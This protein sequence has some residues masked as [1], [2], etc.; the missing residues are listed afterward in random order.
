[1][2][3]IIVGGGKVGTYLAT[4]LSGRGEAVKVIESSREEFPL[5]MRILPP[6]SLVTGSGSD[7]AVLESAGIRRVDVVAAVTGSD[8]TNL[9]VAGLARFEFG[10]RRVIARI[11]HPANAWMFTPKMG[12]DVALN[13]ADLLVHLILEE[14]SVG[15]MMTLLKLRKGEYS[16]VAEKVHGNSPAVGKSIAM[17]NLPDECVIT[18]VIRKGRLT[19]PRGNLVLHAEDEVLS[20]VHSSRIAFLAALLGEKEDQK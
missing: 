19:I 4:L 15:E 12:V 16:L 3:V 5:L 7:P 1:M 2:E 18:A 13:Q 9:V 6:G 8:E 11:N 17:L 20:V 10:V 14:M